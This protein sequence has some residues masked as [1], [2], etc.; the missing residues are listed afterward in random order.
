MNEQ[1][2]HAIEAMNQLS[3]G[4]QSVLAAGN[5]C[6]VYNL[7]A[8]DAVQLSCALNT[9]K[10]LLADQ[11]SPPIFICADKRLVEFAYAEGLT[12]D[13]PQNHPSSSEVV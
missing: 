7:R 3:E 6:R 4:A 1:L 10:N 11:M 2:K 8:Y 5:L 9:H 13:D 12:V